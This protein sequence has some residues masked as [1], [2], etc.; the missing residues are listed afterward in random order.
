L[1]IYC[2]AWNLASKPSEELPLRSRI[3]RADAG[4]RGYEAGD[5]QD[6][7]DSE[8]RRAAAQQ[9]LI[10]LGYILPFETNVIDAGAAEYDEAIAAQAIME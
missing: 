8:E 5:L 10:D 3:R 2:P 4:A 6:A 9:L 7:K 1:G